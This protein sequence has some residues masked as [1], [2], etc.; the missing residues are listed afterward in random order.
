MGGRCDR[1]VVFKAASSRYGWQLGPPLE[2]RAAT[3]EA[4]GSDHLS[5]L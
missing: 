4:H 2:L 5:A 1:A 3:A